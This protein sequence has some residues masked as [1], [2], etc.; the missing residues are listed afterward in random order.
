LINICEPNGKPNPRSA[1][2]EGHG[3]AIRYVAEE[4]KQMK[5]EPLG[6]DGTFIQTIPNSIDETWCPPGIANVVGMV[7]GTTYPDQ[8][9]VYMGILNGVYNRNPETYKTRNNDNFSFA[10]EN[11][12]TA[13][14]GL[15]IAREMSMNPPLRST[16][17]LFQGAGSG[18]TNLGER[19]RGDLD[20]PFEQFKRTQWYKQVCQALSTDVENC[21]NIY[22][23]G[24][25]YWVSNP[26]VN[27]S[28]IDIIIFADRIGS[29]P[30]L[31]KN[32]FFLL[33]GE[34]TTYGADGLTLNNF[35]DEVWPEDADLQLARAPLA[36]IV[37][38]SVETT[39]SSDHFFIGPC[40]NHCDGLKLAWFMQSAFQISSEL[41]DNAR[42]LYAQQLGQREGTFPEPVY[43]T[44]DNLQN[45]N[46]NHFGSTV[47]AMRS[48][49]R[50]TANVVTESLNFTF[51]KTRG[52]RL[53]K[54]DVDHLAKSM[55]VLE[56]DAVHIL[57]EGIK[58]VF[59]GQ[60]NTLL[61]EN[62]SEYQR[63]VNNNSSYLSDPEVQ[64]EIR[65]VYQYVAGLYLVVDYF[66]SHYPDS[67]PYH[68][69]SFGLNIT[70]QPY[71]YKEAIHP[72]ILAITVV[73]AIV[74]VIIV[75]SVS[76]FLFRRKRS[77]ETINA[78]TAYPIPSGLE[79]TEHIGSGDE[80]IQATVLEIE[81]APQDISQSGIF[82]APSD[83]GDTPSPNLAEEREETFIS[84]VAEDGIA[85]VDQCSPDQSELS[86][87]INPEF[88]DQVNGTNCEITPRAIIQTTTH[89]SIGRDLN[90]EAESP[91]MIADSVG[92]TSLQNAEH[93]EDESEV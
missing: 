37:G 35:I 29:P 7:R 34:Q 59:A 68:D 72:K 84:S 82:N 18:W 74:A 41:I 27:L 91:G 33:G 83:S 77:K 6:D 24:L 3:V 80:P 42:G 32:L 66:N 55:T 1:C 12:M 81:L 8:Y 11:G 86:R 89:R 10:Y 16:I 51:D 85:S 39:L 20:G 88:K 2:T 92:S 67:E 69:Q 26:A 87:R 45:V 78:V 76:T 62:V 23:I 43:F 63:Q 58:Y 79:T 46:W 9:V 21:E 15:A 50:N 64:G 52:F 40:G 19:K 65:F 47:S 75:V 53:D 61:A 22:H 71:P 90:V 17:F 36:A 4:L 44:T 93:K 60:I 48:V 56:G 54:A 49:V 5:L 30:G 31:E 57:P 28:S 38:T 14:V 70:T 73:S 13:A 25:T